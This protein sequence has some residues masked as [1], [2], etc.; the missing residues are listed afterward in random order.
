M[1]TW[2]PVEVPNFYNPV[3]TLLEPAA[4]R[5]KWQGMKTAGQIRRERGIKREADQD[6]LYRVSGR[7][8]GVVLRWYQV[9]GC[10]VCMGIDFRTGLKMLLARYFW[11]QMFYYDVW[12]VCLQYGI[13]FNLVA[14]QAVVNVFIHV[15]F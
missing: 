7:D 9:E 14:S 13:V 12:A 5:T 15:R 2:Y 1:R 10:S 11:V 3:T 8:D 6:S 4:D